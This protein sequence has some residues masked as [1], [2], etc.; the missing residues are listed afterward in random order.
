MQLLGLEGRPDGRRHRL[1]YA[2]QQVHHPA[3]GMLRRQILTTQYLNECTRTTHKK[4]A[5]LCPQ[6]A[7]P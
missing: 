7:V 4:F 3:Y 5:S 1:L 6:K 2:P